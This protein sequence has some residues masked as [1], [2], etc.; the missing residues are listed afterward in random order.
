MIRLSSSKKALWCQRDEQECRHFIFKFPYS[1]SRFS[2]F[3]VPTF[4]KGRRNA[5]SGFSLVILQSLPDQ[6]FALFL[7]NDEF[8][9][10]SITNSSQDERDGTHDLIG[11]DW[12]SITQRRVQNWHGL[13]R[14]RL[15]SS[16]S[17]FL[18]NEAFSF[19]EEINRSSAHALPSCITAHTGDLEGHTRSVLSN[20]FPKC[21]QLH[22]ASWQ[23]S[24]NDNEGLWAKRR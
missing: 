23:P 20:Y 16:M 6:K 9:E 1:I 19:R 11:Y 18:I 3:T 2:C 14:F 21:V 10:Y 15:R 22:N 24:T 17:N 4:Y 5:S 7:Q 12:R 13:A 8:G